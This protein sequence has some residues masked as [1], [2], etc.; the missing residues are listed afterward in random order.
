MEPYKFIVGNRVIAISASDGNS[1]IVGVPG[2]V[3]EIHS[4][5]IVGVMYDEIIKGGHNL[6]GNCC[7]GYG[8]YTDTDCLELYNEPET[9]A[10]VD[11]SY[12]EVM[13]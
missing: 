2:T 7:Y 13:V 8:W 9:P 1:S 4:R 6:C 12:D 5:D 3:V 10:D 11:I